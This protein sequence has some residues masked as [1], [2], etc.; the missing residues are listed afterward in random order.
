MAEVTQ[1]IFDFK[2]IAEALV[3]KADIHEGIWGIYVE[4]GLTATNVGQT[5]SQVLPTALVPIQRI[6]IRRFDKENNLAVDASKVN[7]Q[8]KPPVQPRRR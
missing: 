8:T 1:Y 5:E 7:P 2:E 4:F 3:K 6:G